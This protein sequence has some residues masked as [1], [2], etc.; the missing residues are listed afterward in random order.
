MIK[1][2]FSSG[3][4]HIDG[5]RRRIFCLTSESEIQRT[6]KKSEKIRQALFGKAT[7]QGEL[8]IEEK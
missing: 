2:G 8:K 4:T 1:L 5:L 3:P 7:E 6:F